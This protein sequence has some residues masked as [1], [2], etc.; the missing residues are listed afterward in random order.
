MKPFQLIGALLLVTIPERV[1]F[2]AAGL[3]PGSLAGFL[4]GLIHP[5]FTIDHLLAMLAIGVLVIHVEKG[6]IIAVPIVFLTSVLAGEGLEGTGIELPFGPIWVAATV[7][8]LGLL[9]IVGRT[10]SEVLLAIVVA[11]CGVMVG[12]ASDPGYQLPTVP[13]AL[14]MGQLIGGGLIMVIGM[15]LG[16]WIEAS[17]AVSR[18]LGGLVVVG[19]AAAL[20]QA[21]VV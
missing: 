18:C 8:F 17:S 20:V 5:W 1:V 12:Y 13:I 21:C 2:G 3:V 15:W 16:H 19:G 6:S 4:S 9:L 11:A 10:Y 14:L 7:I